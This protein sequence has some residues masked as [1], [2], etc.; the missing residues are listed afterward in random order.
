MFE[1][2]FVSAK[3][4]CWRVYGFLH[5]S[6]GEFEAAQAHF[7]KLSEG[8]DEVAA[9]YWHALANYCDWRAK[10]K[11]HEDALQ[12]VGLFYP[13]AFRRRVERDT[14]DPEHMMEAQFPQMN[15]NDCKHCDM[16][17]QGVCCGAACKEAYAKIMAALAK[18][19]VQQ[20]PL[21]ERLAALAAL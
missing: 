17:A 11:G 9:L 21:L 15:C 16:G 1:R 4:S 6:R 14:Q 19:A 5:L 7:E 10:G 18:S 13:P 3:M 20:E 2:P 8:L 12:L